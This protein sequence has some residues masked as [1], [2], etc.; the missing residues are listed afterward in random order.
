MAEIDWLALQSWL[1]VKNLVKNLQL[2]T[3]NDSNLVLKA[4][5]MPQDPTDDV[6]PGATL[7]ACWALFPVTLMICLPTASA[8]F[9]EPVAEV[10]GLVLQ[11]GL[12]VKNVAT[13]NASSLVLEVVSMF[14]V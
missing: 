11:T 12:L 10:E 14:K 6:G 1:R 8:A 4:V 3:D 7:E 5:K 9:Y 13:E 2:A